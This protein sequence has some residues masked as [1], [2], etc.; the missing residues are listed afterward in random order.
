MCYASTDEVRKWMAQGVADLHSESVRARLG[1]FL[2]LAYQ[3]RA[4]YI[5]GVKEALCQKATM[6]ICRL[7]R[8]AVNVG[9]HEY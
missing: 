6:S 5:A 7:R 3:A 8:Y 9:G 2:R 1:K 4:G